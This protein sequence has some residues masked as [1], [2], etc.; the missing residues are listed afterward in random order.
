MVTKQISQCH[1]GL[2]LLEKKNNTVTELIV[3]TKIHL[4]K[5]RLW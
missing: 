3:A 1:Y 2:N 4:I 5:P